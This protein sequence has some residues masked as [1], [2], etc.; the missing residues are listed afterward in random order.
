[1]EYIVGELIELNKDAKTPEFQ[2]HQL[3]SQIAEGAKGTLTATNSVFKGINSRC[4]R[5]STKLNEFL[6]KLNADLLLDG[7]LINRAQTHLKTLRRDGGIFNKNIKDAEDGLERINGRYQKEIA[8]NR[9]VTFEA[10][11]KLDVIKRLRDIINDELIN[12][13]KAG[14]FVQLEQFKSAMTDLQEK[15]SKVEDTLFSPLVSA[16]VSLANQRNFSDQG[17]LKKI[18]TLLAKIGSNLKAFLKRHKADHKKILGLIGQQR[19]LKG[20]QLRDYMRLKAQIGQDIIFENDA[21]SHATN[22]SQLLKSQI[23]KKNRELKHWSK[24]CNHEKTFGT[25]IVKEITDF[26]KKLNELKGVVAKLH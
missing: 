21:I 16:L 13:S 15:M 4:T 12:G 2:V 5:G 9:R 3:L 6:K 22:S 23:A 7:A 1:M 24:L 20:K 14:A 26:E 8:H 17:I 11:A 25:K 18:L 19:T 10:Y